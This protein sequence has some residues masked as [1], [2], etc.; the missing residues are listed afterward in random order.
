MTYFLPSCEIK[1]FTVN[2]SKEC[3]IFLLIQ[4]LMTSLTPQAV[5]LPNREY[6]LPIHFIRLSPLAVMLLKFL[7]S[8]D[9]QHYKGFVNQKEKRKN[10]M[11]PFCAKDSWTRVQSHTTVAVLGMLVCLVYLFIW[12]FVDAQVIF[13]FTSIYMIFLGL[14]IIVL[15]N[16][17][18]PFL[19]FY[20]L[21]FIFILFS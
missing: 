16:Y 18:R 7:E 11:G 14:F 6:S 3:F 2:L 9:Q 17:W 8:I 13:Y 20:S 1:S 12:W 19:F 4:F 10:L 15:M 5:S 21:L